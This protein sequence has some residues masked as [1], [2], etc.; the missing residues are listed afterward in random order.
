MIIT[1][2][3]QMVKEVIVVK[4]VNER[5]INDAIRLV[6]RAAV[7]PSHD[8]AFLRLAAFQA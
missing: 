3:H 5:R 4:L 2:S 1:P 6:G 7:C 8:F